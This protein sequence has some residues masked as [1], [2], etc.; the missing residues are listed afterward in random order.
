MDSIKI[1]KSAGINHLLEKHPE[2]AEILMAYGLHCIGC[3][4]SEF[5]TIEDGAR[6]H[7]MADEEIEMMIK[8]VNKIVSKKNK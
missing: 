5:D 6:I 2:T 3:Q 7:G 4:F 8:D 1:T